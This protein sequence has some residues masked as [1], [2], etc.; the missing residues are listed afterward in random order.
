LAPEKNMCSLG[1]RFLFGMEL[2]VCKGG[3]GRE[4]DIEGGGETTQVPEPS[5]VKY[6]FHSKYSEK[7]G[8]RNNEV[9]D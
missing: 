2:P 5:C 1:F 7:E 3:K 6:A 8:K 4:V 9:W